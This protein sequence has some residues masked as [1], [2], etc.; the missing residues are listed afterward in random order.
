M[1]YIIGDVHGEFESLLQ[2]VNK[3]PVDANLIFVGD[4]VDRGKKSKE[5]IEFIRKNRFKVVL[6]NHEKMMIDYINSFKI[7]YPN[8]PSMVYW[9]TWINNGGKQTLFSYDI[10]KL[11]K[12][13]GKLYC[14]E[15]EEKFQQ[16]CDD[17]SWLESLPLYIE[18]ENKK[19]D[20]PIVVSH[21]SM[22]NVWHFRNDKNNKSIFEEYCL[23]N[24]I[25]PKE[26]VEI[27]NIFGHTVQ[28]EIDISKH[29]INVDTG[30]HYNNLG[31]GKL[32]SYCIENNN[33][34]SVEKI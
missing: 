21:A 6:G 32:S 18:L 1:T 23:W 15:D 22:A 17:V 19:N 20:K 3:L 16:L 12:Y 9:H 7:S 13:D 31:Y 34:I 10:I 28:K 30:C 24:R 25:N 29:F 5:V 26:D 11:D 27:F 8:L 2:L 14:N 4:L 33:V